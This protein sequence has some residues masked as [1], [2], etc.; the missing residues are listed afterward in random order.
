MEGTDQSVKKGR[1]RLCVVAV[2]AV[3]LVGGL[4]AFAATGPGKVA[5]LLS[6]GVVG[7]GSAATV[8]NT[9]VAAAPKNRIA[10]GDTA[11]WIDQVQNGAAK[12]GSARVTGSFDPARQQLVTGSFK[13]PDS[14]STSYSTDGKTWVGVEPAVASAVTAVRA[15]AEFIPELGKPGVVSRLVPP[16]IAAISTVGGG[17]DSFFPIFRKKNVYGIPHH[18][19]PVLTCYDKQTG[20]NC[21]TIKPAKTLMTSDYADA[22]VD[23]RNGWAYIPTLEV[24]PS[25][26]NVLL[27]C[28]DLDNGSDCGATGVDTDGSNPEGQPGV[29]NVGHPYLSAP[30]SYG[31][32]VFFAYRKE[33][34]GSLMVACVTVPSNMPCAAQPYSAGLPYS[35]DTGIGGVRS[36][37]A[38]WSP[39]GVTPY[40]GDGKVSYVAVP[41]GISMHNLECFDSV[42]KAACAGVARVGWDGAQNPLVHQTVAG[43]AD[44]WCSR[45]KTTNPLTCYSF[46]GAS[47]PVTPALEAWMPKGLLSW[48]APLGAYGTMSPGRSFVAGSSAAN[49][50]TICFDWSTNASC[51]GFPL[52]LPL[53]K[54]NYSL[55]RDPFAPACVWAMSDDG[56]L[57]TV[58]SFSGVSGCGSTTSATASPIYCDGKAGHVTGWDAI[59]LNDLTGGHKGLTV[60]LTNALGARIPGWSAAKFGAG[61]S[62]I[63]I[64]SIPY[65]AT[66]RTITA[67]FQLNGVSAAAFSS[68]VPTIEITWKGDPLQVC[69][70]T[71]AIGVCPTV[72]AP[73]VAKAVSRRSDAAVVVA[74][75]TDA[76]G[77]DLS[78]D[79]VTPLSCATPGVSVA[80][81]VNGTRNPIAPGQEI[82]SGSPVALTYT[83]GNTGTTL[84]GTPAVTDDA[85]TPSTS[86]DVTP[87][88]VSGDSNNNG[89]IDPNETWIYQAA[90]ASVSGQQQS[91]PTVSGT[92]LD[93]TGLAIVGMSSLTASDR[94]FYFI[95]DPALTL[96]AGIYVN[97]VAGSSCATASTSIYSDKDAPITYCYT[98]TNSGNVSLG[99]ILLSDPAVGARNATVTVLSGA[100]AGLDP[101][102]SVTVAFTAINSA[103]L[104]ASASV[105]GQ[106]G[107]GPVVVA[108]ASTDR[109]IGPRIF[110]AT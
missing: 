72:Y 12:I 78:F 37:A 92:P 73:L 66:N 25:G 84:I 32:E 19:N 110:P 26:N 42:T 40:R 64:S 97:A 8:G 48:V 76:I 9:P 53:S 62:S 81:A 86:D 104:T 44:G 14:W 63:G 16:S 3:S 89:A 87:A 6:D 17:G 96:Q 55:R 39:D 91:H 105:S 94:A 47:L 69:T 31:N 35:P 60:T 7:F 27:Q 30:W 83:V 28:L 93:A 4:A 52:V 18:A 103:D 85:G 21:G 5:T 108:A 79:S 46:T 109:H 59:K 10:A 67:E 11:L 13:V 98:V 71:R 33:A 75:V 29:V 68:G 99:K 1:V 20:A 23:S 49:S 24:L 51:S 106:P 22:W 41:S 61:T 82:R 36:F 56:F 15:S 95:A 77:I 100:L 2:A 57:E 43:V 34:T 88:Y 38:F 74:A 58:E 70:T 45:P 65:N 80:A 102:E 101:G 50:Q 90:G 107:S 54:K